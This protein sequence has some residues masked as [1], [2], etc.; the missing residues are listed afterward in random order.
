M[1]KK[2]KKENSVK[3]KKCKNLIGEYQ[4]D[5]FTEMMIENLVEN[6]NDNSS[7]GIK[8]EPDFVVAYLKKCDSIINNWKM[9]EDT[10]SFIKGGFSLLASFIPYD[11]WKRDYD[12][13]AQSNSPE[14]I[15]N[16]IN[17]GGYDSAEEAI[18]EIDYE[19]GC[20]INDFW[21][22]IDDGVP[23]SNWEEMKDIIEDYEALVA[24]VEEDEKLGS[25]DFKHYDYN[26]DINEID[27]Y[28]DS[29]DN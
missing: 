6:A 26:N 2:I 4:K 9:S 17:S 11:C 29:L 3:E 10:K 22:S 13:I 7:N 28:Y 14:D 25:D 24:V 5:I 20:I 1:I 15:E 16:L 21:N 19:I 27:K 23:Y 18:N 8:L 12:W